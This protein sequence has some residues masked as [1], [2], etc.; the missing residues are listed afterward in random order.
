MNQ[1]I[2]PQSPSTLIDRK[3]EQ[4][5]GWRGQTLAKVRRIILATDPVNEVALPDLIR[6]AVS[7]NRQTKAKPKP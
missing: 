3:I 2:A 1:S 6:A 5:G 7:L 4:L